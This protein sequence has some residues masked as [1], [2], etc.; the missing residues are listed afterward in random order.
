MN[1]DDE[2]AL[3]FADI[4][5]GD[6]FPADSVTTALL[7][8]LVSARPLVVLA[9]MQRLVE[10]D[11]PTSNE[12][13]GLLFSLSLGAS[14]EA[15]DAFREADAVGA[16]DLLTGLDAELDESL[17]RLRK[18]CDPLKGSSLYNLVLVRARNNAS[19]HWSSKLVGRSLLKLQDAE[20]PC[21]IGSGRF[22]DTQI[23]L[24]G[25]LASGILGEQGLSDEQLSP[26]GERLAEFQA[27]LFKVADGAYTAKLAEGPS[28]LSRDRHELT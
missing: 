20:M 3:E 9:R 18:H 23:P 2:Q 12:D 10:R 7:T 22:V 24:A 19:Y 15:A 4:R 6:F 8:F 17:E 13:K 16:L 26:F 25:G 5:V 1:R 27:D 14:K 11:S 21:F 28:R